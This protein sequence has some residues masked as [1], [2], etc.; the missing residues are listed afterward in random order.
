MEIIKGC[1][2]VNFFI[3]FLY[4]CFGSIALSIVNIDLP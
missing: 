1:T 4:T 3:N 2:F